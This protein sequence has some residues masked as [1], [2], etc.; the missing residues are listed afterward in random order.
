MKKRKDYSDFDIIRFLED[1]DIPYRLSGKNIGKGWVGFPCCFCGGRGYHGGVN[2]IHKMFSCWQCAESASPPKLVKQILNCSWAKAYNVVREYSGRNTAVLSW[3]PTDRERSQR[4]VRLPALTGPL[5]GPGKE[6]LI[7]RGFNP[8]AVEAKYGIKETGPLG[9]YKFRLIIPIYFQKELVSFTSR[10]Y[11]GRGEPKY[12]AQPIKEAMIPVKDCLYNID[13]AKDKLLI[14]EGPM[15][16]WR[17][18]DGAVAL[19]GLHCSDAQQKILFQWWR[20][21]PRSSRKK[22]VILLLDP[23]T[24]RAVDKLYYTL[25]SF[26]RDIK[27]VELAGQDPAELTEEEAMN[28]KLQVF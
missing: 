22:K 12:K 19:F 3:T 20:H 21:K 27:I 8:G 11:T 4:P 15:D 16:A 14:V 24:R 26:I 10:D 23:G 5:S 6:Y 25:T 9:K 28:L 2:L 17:M 7:S 1:T 18:G 13:S